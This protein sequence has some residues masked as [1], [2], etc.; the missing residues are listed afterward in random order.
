M[1]I[2]IASLLARFCAPCL[3]FQKQKFA[4]MGKVQIAN[5]RQRGLLQP[6]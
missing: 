6:L 1:E 3:A 4:L 5:L 2:L